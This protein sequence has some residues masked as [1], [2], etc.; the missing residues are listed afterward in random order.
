M[1]AHEQSVNV[2]LIFPEN[3]VLARPGHTQSIDWYA[4][5]PTG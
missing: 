2:L 1:R 3:S 5:M 4:Q